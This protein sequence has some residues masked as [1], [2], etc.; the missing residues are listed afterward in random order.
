MHVYTPYT[1]TERGQGRRRKR[2]KRRNGERGGRGGKSYN[3]RIAELTNGVLSGSPLVGVFVQSTKRLLLPRA[4]ANLGT[5]IS[6][7][8]LLISIKV[9]GRD[10]GRAEF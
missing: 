6:R 10:I 3:K 7:N 1:A 9:K 2:K 4:P 8:C 5:N